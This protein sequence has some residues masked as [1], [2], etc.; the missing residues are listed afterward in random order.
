MCACACYP[1]ISPCHVSIGL[2]DTLNVSNTRDRQ[3]GET[4]GSTNSCVQ[5]FWEGKAPNIFV[6]FCISRS[7]FLKQF[8]LTLH[9]TRSLKC[10]E[11]FCRDF[12]ELLKRL[13]SS[14][15]HMTLVNK[16]CISH[17]RRPPCTSL[18]ADHTC[19]IDIAAKPTAALIDS[20]T[21]FCCICFM[22]FLLRAIKSHTNLHLTTLT[23]L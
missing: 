23:W 10:I 9:L 16:W 12:F 17:S 18:Q 13:K 1:F 5:Q 22:C 21:C 19:F 2:N 4:V 7:F 3:K 20:S 11:K 8:F 14:N 15:H 6:L